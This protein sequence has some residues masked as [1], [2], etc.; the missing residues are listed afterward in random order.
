MINQN[1]TITA[2]N[3]VNEI[4]KQVKHYPSEKIYTIG[5]ANDVCYF[6]MYLNGILIKK[7]GNNPIGSTATE[8][9]HLINKSGKY[10]VTYKMYP[11]GEEK[12]HYNQTFNTF[13]D[14]TV[15]EFDLKSYDLKNEAA[16]DI[17][18][19]SY[20]VPKTEEK[21][22]ENYSKY[23]FIATG[24]TY[25]EGSFD[26]E[27]DVQYTLNFPFENAQD[28]RK[29]DKKQLE[30]KLLKKYKEVASIYQNNDID[31]IARLEF[32]GLRDLYV[33]NYKSKEEIQEN[34]NEYLKAYKSKS[35][36]M[37]PI[38]N[39][40]LEYFADGKFVALMIDTMDNRFRGHNALWAKV[41]Y[42]GG[43]RPIFINLLFYIPQGETE[44]KVY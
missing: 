41:D 9:N 20:E 38:E 28:L 23:K 30:E 11:L 33:S 10:T 16:D 43:L 25:Y 29:M 3:I 42:D 34:W 27:V 21:V 36:Q 39:Y 15:L 4:A 13:M 18:Y 44:F 8:I 40:K 31:N 37:Q 35:L 22:T 17:E 14:N 19:T 32:D 24:K 5:Y 26:I 1:P 6:D 2:D 7:S 12:N